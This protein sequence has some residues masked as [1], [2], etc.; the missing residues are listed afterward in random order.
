[1]T[2]PASQD[3]G[4]ECKPTG[5]NWTLDAVTDLQH[6]RIARSASHQGIGAGKSAATGL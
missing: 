2:A 3:R 4:L 6:E 1:M 5:L